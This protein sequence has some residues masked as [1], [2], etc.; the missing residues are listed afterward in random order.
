MI[1]PET[2]ATIRVLY[3]APDTLALYGIPY[4]MRPGQ[5]PRHL[6]ESN[7]IPDTIATAQGWYGRTISSPGPRADWIW[8]GSPGWW[9]H[10]SEAEQKTIA[11]W[12]APL[13]ALDVIPSG[14]CEWS[15]IPACAGCGGR[16]V[17]AHPGKICPNRPTDNDDPRMADLYDDS[18]QHEGEV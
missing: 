1:T 5:S 10:L 8:L 7:S 4:Y 6:W 9:G 3:R 13:R 17:G 14:P 15:E 2:L 16:G 11:A 18:P 12:L